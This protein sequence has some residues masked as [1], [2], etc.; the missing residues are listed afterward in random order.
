MCGAGAGMRGGKCLVMAGG[1]PQGGLL[2]GV[3]RTL[4]GPSYGLL[5]I[6]HV[7]SRAGAM[8]STDLISSDSDSSI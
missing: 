3:G 1:S 8:E 6:L 7:V 4:F 2:I 5:N